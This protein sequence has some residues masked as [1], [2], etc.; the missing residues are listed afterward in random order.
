MAAKKRATKGTAGTGEALNDGV[1]S[2]RSRSIRKLGFDL[3]FKCDHPLVGSV[4]PGRGGGRVSGCAT[5]S[6]EHPR[7]LQL[8]VGLPHVGKP[9]RLSTVRDRL[10]GKTAFGEGRALNESRRAA[11]QEAVERYRHDGIPAPVGRV[12]PGRAGSSRCDPE[13]AV[14]SG[15]NDARED[16]EVEAAARFDDPE[17]VS[18]REYAE[19]VRSTLRAQD[20]QRFDLWREVTTS[21][22]QSYEVAYPRSRG[23]ESP[24]AA[25]ARKRAAFVRAGGDVGSG[26]W[27]DALSDATRAHKRR[28][29]KQSAGVISKRSKGAGGSKGSKGSKRGA[30]R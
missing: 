29:E 8:V 13:H 18:E 22:V 4:I 28:K 16:A 19:G 24:Q 20:P 23:Y 21:C 6:K 15:Y 7:E 1:T 11:T 5:P 12:Y 10:R 2:Y 26:D 14:W 27:D 9:L 30:A 17:N 3:F 25:I